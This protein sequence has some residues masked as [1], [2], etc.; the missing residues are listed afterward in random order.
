MEPEEM[1]PEDMGES[2]LTPTQAGFNVHPPR[3][4]P[5][6]PQR[7]ATSGAVSIE[8]IMAQRPLGSTAVP[9]T[10]WHSADQKRSKK[11]TGEDRV[12]L[13]RNSLNDN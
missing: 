11:I 7:S 6:S 1:N 9:P 2:V 4:P 8:A 5:R 13:I 3:G 12:C 10:G